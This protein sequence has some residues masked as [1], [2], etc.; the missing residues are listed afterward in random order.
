MKNVIK[1]LVFVAFTAASLGVMAEGTEIKDSTIA[2]TSINS[3]NLNLS[4]GEESL[5]STGS[6]NI[7]NGAEIKNST[8]LNSSANAEN[9]NLSI[10]EKSV[11]TAGS[12]TVE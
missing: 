7:R 12:V 11:A 6:V 5:A 4:I 9:L 3:Q 10:G 1:G 2:N 8:V